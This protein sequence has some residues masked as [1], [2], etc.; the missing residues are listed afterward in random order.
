MGIS[1]LEDLEFRSRFVKGYDNIRF[2]LFSGNGFTD[3]LTELAESRD[4]LEL[5]GLNDLF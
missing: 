3:E 4:D 5:V 2:M 1:V